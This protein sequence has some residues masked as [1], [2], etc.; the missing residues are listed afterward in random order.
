[1]GSC[2][3]QMFLAALFHPA[4]IAHPALPA[5]QRVAEDLDAASERLQ[6]P[7]CSGEIDPT[8]V[9]HSAPGGLNELQTGAQAGFPLELVFAVLLDEGPQ[10]CWQD[11]MTAAAASESRQSPPQ[12]EMRLQQP[13][14]TAIAGHLQRSSPEV[15]AHTQALAA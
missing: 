8:P 7:V 15:Q 4:L 5:D 14:A 3:V 11:V 13:P 9:V 1:M 12:D 6:V 10:T 2:L